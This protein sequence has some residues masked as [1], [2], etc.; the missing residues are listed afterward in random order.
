MHRL[1]ILR[2]R[3]D[4]ISLSIVFCTFAFQLMA[5]TL[6]WPWYA[7]FGVLPLVRQVNL[8]EHNHAHLGIFYYRNLNELLGWICLISNGAPLEIYRIH[9]VANHHRF[10]Q[11]FDESCEDWSSTFGFRG[12]H[13]P[14]R[15]VG[16]IYYV[17]TFPIITY[18]SFLIW[19]LRSRD[20]GST[21]RFLLSL[22]ILVATCLVL[23]WSNPAGFFVFFVI[24]WIVVAF[25]LGYNN[26][27]HHSGCDTTDRFKAANENLTLFSTVFGFNIGYHIEHHLKPSLHWSLLPRFHEEIKD[28]V[29][30]ERYFQSTVRKAIADG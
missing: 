27:D 18:C 25:G 19:F 23:A 17:L 1:R 26:Y 4:A 2:Y 9:H 3:I 10:N 6:K 16:K 22:L 30:D 24:P 13:F 8:I 5:L 11:R 7:V 12:A 20:S 15:P 14:D 28:L 21:Q 29:P